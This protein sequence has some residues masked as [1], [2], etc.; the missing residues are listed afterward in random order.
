MI[1]VLCCAVHLVSVVTVPVL[2]E[3]ESPRVECVGGGCG[4]VVYGGLADG[5]GRRFLKC[6]RICVTHSAGEGGG[7]ASQQLA[8]RVYIGIGGRLSSLTSW[9]RVRSV[10]S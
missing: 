2:E 5:D 9:R 7:G 8:T 6:C 3:G 10:T 1:A 4:S